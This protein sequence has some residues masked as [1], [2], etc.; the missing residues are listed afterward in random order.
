MP[1][2]LFDS[3]D[4][5]LTAL[6]R[7]LARRFPAGSVRSTGDPTLSHRTL[8]SGRFRWIVRRYEPATPRREPGERDPARL[9]LYDRLEDHAPRSFPDFEQEARL[10]LTRRGSVLHSPCEGCEGGRLPCRDCKGA[11]VTACPP[12]RECPDC[13]TIT[14]CPHCDGEGRG[15]RRRS[16]S[17]RR[18]PVR[19]GSGSA[20][21]STGASAGEGEATVQ[22]GMCGEGG[23]CSGCRGSGRIDCPDC[24]GEGK[25]T[26]ASCGGDGT[27]DHASCRG[28]GTF[29]E[30][31]EGAVTDTPQVRRIRVS[32]EVRSSLIARWCVRLLGHTRR[33][34]VDGDA[35]LPADLGPRH[36]EAVEEARRAV[37]EAV[38]RRVEL[39]WLRLTRAELSTDPH[40]VH[41]LFRPRRGTESDVRV[42]TLPSRART[43]TMGAAALLCSVLLILGSFLVR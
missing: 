35:S 3:E 10:V 26:C 39:R 34:E 31:W 7:R 12:D 27:T 21:G 23:A 20:K 37:P 9:G 19:A 32:H 4:A 2:S 30:W 28:T 6:E 41:Y 36:R 18:H 29:T 33:A 1:E 22:C 15:R 40:R 5:L 25:L 17:G 42:L 14:P 38:A 8:F 13:R 43:A 16:R 24:K 11:P